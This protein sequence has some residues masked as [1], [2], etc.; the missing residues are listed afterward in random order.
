MNRMRSYQNGSMILCPVIEDY[1]LGKITLRIS[2]GV[3]HKYKMRDFKC[4]FTEHAMEFDMGE[5]YSLSTSF[6][7]VQFHEYFL[8][9][10]IPHFKYVSTQASIYKGRRT[11]QLDEACVVFSLF[12]RNIRFPLD[13]WMK[14]LGVAEEWL[15]PENVEKREFERLRIK[16]RLEA[17]DE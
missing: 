7:K 1:H 17:G 13:I 5:S 15:K 11:K 3:S 9:K 8:D 16:F 6:G 4:S 12:N 14:F 2:S 10:E